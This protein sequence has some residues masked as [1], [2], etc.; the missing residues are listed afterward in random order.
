MEKAFTLILVSDDFKT[1][2]AGYFLKGEANFWWETTRALESEGPVSWARFTELFLEKYFPDC[3]QSQ[4]EKAR[5]FQQGLKP[6]VRSGV[7]ALQLKTYTSVVQAALVIESDQI[8]ASKERSDK[9]RK[10]DSGA[11]KAD[12]EESSQKFSRKFGRNRNKRFRKQ[13]FS[14][15]SFG[16]TSIASA[17]A[18]STKPTVE[19]KSFDKEHGGQ[20]RKDVQCFK[21]DKKGHYASEYNSGNPGVTYFT[22]ED[23]VRVT[24]QGQKLEKKFLSILEV[25]KLLR[26]GCEAYLAH[27]VDTEKE[28]L[29][30]DEIPVVSEFSDVFP[31]ELPGL[32]PDREIEFSIDL[33]PGAEPVSKAPFRMTPVEMKELVIQLQ[34]LLDK[35]TNDDHA[36]HLRIALQRL[37][38]K[39]LYAKFLK[40]EFWL[41]EVQFLGHIVGR[42]GIKVD[43][44]KIEADFA[45]ITTPL[46]KLTRKNER[47]FW[48]EKCEESFQELKK[49][50]LTAP[51]LALPDE[52]GNFMIYND[53]SLKELG[54]VLMQYDKVIAYASR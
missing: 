13:G 14:Q 34:D 21:C 6:E 54:C 3:L 9:K 28:A 30:L 25:R 41:E 31:D 50:L 20:C 43:P 45:K 2:Y 18:Q 42:D 48:T 27:V 47:F 44:V 15:T 33:I 17:P 32:P 4:L 52:T 53:A 23:N 19:C 12:R 1:D 22:C 36:E 38:E 7:V 49:R 51:V 29:S 46:T 26:Q 40:C 11:D 8:L 37:K 16:V 24:Y 10:F 35:G 5:R 39:Q